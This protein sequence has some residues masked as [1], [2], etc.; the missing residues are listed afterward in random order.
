MMYHITPCP[1]PRMTRADKWKRRPCVV[2][3]FDFRDQVR[4]ARITLTDTPTLLFHLPMPKSWSKKRR[5]EMVGQPHASRPD[6]DNLI[7]AIADA[8]FDEDSHI[9]KFTAEKRWSY[10]GAIQIL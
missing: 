9:W 5:R 8:V 10:E 1:A 7:K 3:Y 2:R 4:A 6:L